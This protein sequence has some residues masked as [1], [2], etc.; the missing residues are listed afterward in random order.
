MVSVMGIKSEVFGSCAGEI[1]VSVEI[2][3]R[4]VWLCCGWKYMYE[5]YF[6]RKSGSI[7]GVVVGDG[8]R[9]WRGF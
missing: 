6:G 7:S 5:V 4:G 2:K 3:N 9:Y 1:N 8:A